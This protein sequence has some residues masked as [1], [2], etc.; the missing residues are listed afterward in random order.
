MLS[1]FPH[2]EIVFSSADNRDI[3]ALPY[4]SFHFIFL[5]HR[6][7]QYFFVRNYKSGHVLDIYKEGK[8]VGAE[9]SDY[10]QNTNLFTRKTLTLK[11]FIKS[12]DM[13]WLSKLAPA[14]NWQQ[15]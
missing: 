9:V 2:E 7:A 5:P 15:Q 8:S 4:V 12:N 11:L 6:Q 14:T 13:A 3:N 1:S 10:F